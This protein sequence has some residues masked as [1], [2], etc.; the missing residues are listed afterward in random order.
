MNHTTDEFADSEF[1]DLNRPFFERYVDLRVRGYGSRAAFIRV[2]GVDN[3]GNPQEGYRRTQDIEETEWY[4]S[5]FELRLKEIKDSELWN[6]KTSI[7]E[8]L[9]ILRGDLVKDS[10]RL[11]AIKELNVMGGITIVDENGKTKA[12]RSLDDFY[13][14]QA[15]P[16]APTQPAETPAPATEAPDSPATGDQA[17]T[18]ESQ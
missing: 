7:H 16:S 3:Y 11:N 15:T 18:V 5:N 13:R 8:L 12:G 1:I 14:Q 10:V 9:S 6:V 17:S 2:F 4:R